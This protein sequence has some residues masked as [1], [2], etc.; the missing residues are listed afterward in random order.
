MILSRRLPSALP[1]ALL[2]MVGGC[3]SIRSVLPWTSNKED[4]NPKVNLADE[5]PDLLYSNGITR[6]RPGP[7]T[8]S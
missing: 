4:E 8:R 5:S 7:P 6:I 1:L 3:Q 2:L